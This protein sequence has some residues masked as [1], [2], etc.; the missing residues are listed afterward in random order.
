MLICVTNRRLCP[1]G[2]FLP[3]I[4]RLAAA[5]P[6]AVL[7]REK[8]LDPPAYGRLAQQ[9][10]DICDR[11]GVPLIAHQNAAVA[12]E[13]GLARLH[14][15]LP[16]LR[17]YC[18]QGPMIVGAS[19]HSAAEAAEAQT[20]GAAYLVAG[21]IFA[22]GSKQ[23]LPPRGLPWLRQICRAV[24]LPVFAIGGIDADNAPEV[25]ACGAAG[26]CV[27]SAAMT[28]PDPAALVQAFNR[29]R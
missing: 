25:L 28:C 1:A 12:E 19:V 10:K 21:H 23:G 17:A 2:E 26:V 22:T 18:K 4:A 24:D 13:L 3:R 8:D 15:P 29:L 9:V 27:M 20:L 7:L 11:H 16:A 6:Y 14:L 5:K